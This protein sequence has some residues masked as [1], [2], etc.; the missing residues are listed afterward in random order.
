MF[1]FS[2]QL[3]GKFS[4]AEYLITW[5]NGPDR[6]S[7][8]SKSTKCNNPED[9]NMNKIR[10]KSLLTH[11]IISAANYSLLVT[12]TKEE[13]PFLYTFCEASKEAAG[14]FDTDSR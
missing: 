10:R 13:V 6:S 7:E 8:I 2:G 4:Q 11:T 1:S 9:H 5:K 3:W 12:S 14:I